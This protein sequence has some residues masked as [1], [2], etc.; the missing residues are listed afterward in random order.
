MMGCYHYPAPAAVIPAPC[1]DSTYVRLKAVPVHSLSPRE[2]QT[3]R[4]RDQACLQPMTQARR[5]SIV[6]DDVANRRSV[7]GVLLLLSFVGLLASLA[8]LK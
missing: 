5:D 6:D 1:A 4:D 7:G 3:F 2:Y 8:A